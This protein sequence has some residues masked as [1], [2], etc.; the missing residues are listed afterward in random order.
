ML[1]F[2]VAAGLEVGG[3]GCGATAGPL[4]VFGPGERG[5]LDDRRD[6]HF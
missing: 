6:Q 3:L 5:W 4:S 2:G 1:L